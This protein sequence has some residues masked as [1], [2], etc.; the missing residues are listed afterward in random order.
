MRTLRLFAALAAAAAA[1]AVLRAQTAAPSAAA[2]PAKAPDYSGTWELN[3]SASNFGPMP[4]PSKL[5]MSVTHAANSVTVVNASVTEQGEQ[6]TTNTFVIGGPAAA[7][8]MG[9]AVTATTAVSWD[10]GVLLFKTDLQQN[11]V[12]IPVLTR[13][14][15]APDGKRLTIDRNI[16][17]PVGPMTMQLVMDRK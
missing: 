13:W 6:K 2:A 1:P 16:T 14:T 17:T 10:A 15:L 11:G 4:A 12:D 3:P 9:P 8:D 5:T 7:Q